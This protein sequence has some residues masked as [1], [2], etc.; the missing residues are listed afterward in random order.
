MQNSIWSSAT[1]STGGYPCSWA[2]AT[3][4]C[5]A[6]HANALG[7]YANNVVAAD[8]NGD[9]NVDLAFTHLVSDS[10]SV[11]FNDDHG[12]F[13]P[14]AQ[15][16]VGPYPRGLAAADLTGD[17]KPDPIDLVAVDLDR[18]GQVD[19]A[20]VNRTSE[21]LSIFLNQ[22]QGRFALGVQYPAGKLPIAAVAGDFNADNTVDLM[23]PSNQD[24]ALTLL[25]ND[26]RGVFSASVRYGSGA[27]PFGL[28][29]ADFNGDSADDLALA[30]VTSNNVSILLGRCSE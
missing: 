8:L 23:V 5:S 12:Q 19:I 13:S 28:V 30:N 18:D 17:G 4:R 24:G 10:V 29:A 21:T 14:A 16:S 3:A 27:D 15:F 7:P 9:G 6:A 2:W 1:T 25:A 26:G 20:T 22:G 11:L